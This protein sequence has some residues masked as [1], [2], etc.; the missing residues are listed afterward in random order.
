MFSWCKHWLQLITL[1]SVLLGS[2]HCLVG[3]YT[4]TYNVIRQILKSCSMFHHISSMIF[5]WQ[6]RGKS[7]G[8]FCFIKIF[9]DSTTSYSNKYTFL[10]H[11]L[12]NGFLFSFRISL[13][14]SYI[15]S[16]EVIVKFSL[17]VC[18]SG[19]LLQ[20]CLS[21]EYIGGGETSAWLLTSIG[22]LL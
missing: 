20:G 22:F 4:V 6:S 7:L 8:P 9:Y 18:T 19:L 10:N 11:I 21:K 3:Y 13:E 14:K 2:M 1:W 17:S 15:T 12:G 16:T 5:Y